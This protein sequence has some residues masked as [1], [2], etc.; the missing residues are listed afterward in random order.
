MAFVTT[1]E[2]V[3][4]GV[5]DW[6]HHHSDRPSRD[7]TATPMNTIVLLLLLAAPFLILGIVIAVAILLIGNR[8]AHRPR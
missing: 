2:D 4:E 6:Q 1:P 7:G 3:L 5:S 8:T